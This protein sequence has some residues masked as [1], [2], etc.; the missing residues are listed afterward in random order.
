[1]VDDEPGIA[2]LV[3]LCL[4][5]LD[6]R[7]LLADGHVNALRMA[8]EHDIGL[9]LLDLAL[10]DEDGLDIIPHLRKDHQLAR[11]PIVAFT[12]HDSRRQ[13]AF[14][15]G[16]DSF[17]CRPFAPADLTSTVEANILR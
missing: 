2:S 14:D 15:R 4:N 17:L 16:V 3:A 13:E 8:R 6:V 9:V 12:S 5:H 7:A 1:M 10:G 11:V